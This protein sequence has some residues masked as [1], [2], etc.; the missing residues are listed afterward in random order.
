MIL[1]PYRT[2]TQTSNKDMYE[3]VPSAP[4]PHRCSLQTILKV[5]RHTYSSCWIKLSFKHE[6]ILGSGLAMWATHFLLH[7]CT[8][9]NIPLAAFTVKPCPSSPIPAIPAFS[10]LGK[11]KVL[12]SPNTSFAPQWYHL[13]HLT[14]NYKHLH[15]LCGF[16]GFKRK[17]K[18]SKNFVL[19]FFL[20]HLGQNT[21][22][23]LWSNS[24]AQ[25]LIK[26]H[27]VTLINF[28]PTT[29]GWEFYEIIKICKLRSKD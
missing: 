17:N 1:I 2:D 21:G 5:H 13:P 19:F 3:W 14:L 29:K 28:C 6:S 11:I 12:L 26:W 18:E 24:R 23:F 4:F 22:N 20:Y 10:P 15:T 25:N 8:S 27:H 7:F 16:P 9:T